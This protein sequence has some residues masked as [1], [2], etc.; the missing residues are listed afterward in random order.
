MVN[1]KRQPANNNGIIITYVF[2]NMEVV[3]GSIVL[4]LT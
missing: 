2:F 4:S 1:Q 3:S